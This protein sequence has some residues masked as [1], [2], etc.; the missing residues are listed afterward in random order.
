MTSA[1]PHAIDLVAIRLRSQRA[2]D[3]VAADIRTPEFWRALNP[4]LTVSDGPVAAGPPLGRLDPSCLEGAARQLRA[5]GYCQLPPVVAP[6]ELAGLR[7]GIERIAAQGLRAVFI[8]VYDEPYALFRRLAAMLEPVLG[9]RPLL[10]PREIAGFFVPSGDPA[11]TRLSAYE[12]H[13]DWL[14]GDP[15]VLRHDL[16]DVL[17]L[18][19]PLADVTPLDSCIYVVPAPCD[20]DYHAAEPRR[21]WHDVRLQD[22]RAVPAAAGSVLAWTTHLIHWGSRSSRYATGPRVS[23]SAN[24]HRRGVPPLDEVAETDGAFPFAD[25]VRWVSGKI[26]IEA[27]AE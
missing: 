6:A 27:E 12:P 25:R 23:V 22:I 21:H 14:G 17:N 15:G 13:R 16:P 8:W 9:V 10:V 20:A 3:R 4:H 18:W 11:W 26:G 5:D 1:K 2:H 24:L 7:T 19:V